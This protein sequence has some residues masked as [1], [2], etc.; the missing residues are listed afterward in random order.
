[1]GQPS[2]SMA[3]NDP[4]R[5]LRPQVAEPPAQVEQR[6][7]IELAHGLLAAAELQRDALPGKA[8]EGA[9]L[10][11]GSAIRVESVQRALQALHGLLHGELRGDG[12][13]SGRDPS[14]DALDR[15]LATAPDLVDDPV[16]RG[17]G[18]AQQELLFVAR[19][20]RKTTLPQTLVAQLTDR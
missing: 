19:I 17:S 16:A 9:Q 3:R 2:R 12:G 7:V 5:R 10:D 13:R 4:Q 11:R 14:A 20:A 1:M 15:L 8:I 18:H 6:P